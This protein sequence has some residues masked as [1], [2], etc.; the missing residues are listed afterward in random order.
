MHTYYSQLHT[1]SFLLT[2]GS[3]DDNYYATESMLCI[4]VA[5]VWML[6]RL[7]RGHPAICWHTPTLVKKVCV[8]M[9]ARIGTSALKV[10]EVV[11]RP[12]SQNLAYT[13][14]EGNQSNS[15]VSNSNP[16]PPP[17]YHTSNCIFDLHNMLHVYTSQYRIFANM[18]TAGAS[19]PGMTVTAGTWIWL[20]LAS[21]RISTA[22]T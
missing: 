2:A 4:L 13:S 14:F 8:C 22:G 9:C 7:W 20:E 6:Q 16:I 21:I 19:Q 18:V 17:V 11:K 10:A 5:L 12:S 3:T 1:W 15:S